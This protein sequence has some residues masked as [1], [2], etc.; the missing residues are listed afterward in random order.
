MPLIDFTAV[1]KSTNPRFLPVLV[2]APTIRKIDSALRT[3]TYIYTYSS[4]SATQA[5]APNRA[6]SCI[7]RKTRVLYVPLTELKCGK[8]YVKSEIRARALTYIRARYT[9]KG[10]CVIREICACLLLRSSRARILTTHLLL[11]DNRLSHS[12]PFQSSF[13]EF[14]GTDVNK[15]SKWR[16]T[17]V[18]PTTYES[19]VENRYR[20]THRCYIRAALTILTNYLYARICVRESSYSRIVFELYLDSSWVVYYVVAQEQGENVRISEKIQ[21]SSR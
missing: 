2:T 15:I 14:R 6:Y 9:Y 10:S 3:Y 1:T 11:D 20:W 17:R 5:P 18:T 7:T 16:R 4:S 13:Y 12:C 19:R 8:R 21:V